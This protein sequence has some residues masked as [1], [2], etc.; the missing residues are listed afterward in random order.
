MLL[1]MSKKPYYCPSPDGGFPDFIMDLNNDTRRRTFMINRGYL[2]ETD[3]LKIIKTLI[4]LIKTLLGTDSNNIENFINYLENNI[5]LRDKILK[6]VFSDDFLLTLSEK[7]GLDI[8]IKDL[9]GEYSKRKLQLT[10]CVQVI[11][12]AIL[13]CPNYYTLLDELMSLTNLSKNRVREMIKTYIPYLE[14]I[15]KN[16]DADKWLP[17]SDGIYSKTAKNYVE[18]LRTC[19]RCKRELPIEKFS[20]RNRNGS[21]L[22]SWCKECKAESRLILRFTKKFKLIMERFNGRCTRCGVS[23]VFLLATVE[24]HHPNH[25]YYTSSWRLMKE[26]SYEKILDWAIRD[27]VVALCGNCHKEITSDI[28]TEFRDIILYPDLF[29]ISAREIH[30]FIQNTI[31][32]HPNYIQ[33]NENLKYS[34]KDS[35]MGYIRKRYTFLQ[36]Y[37]GVCIVCD[38]ISIQNLMA[39]SIHHRHPEILLK[40]SKWGDI[41]RKDSE[42]ILHILINEDC[43]ALCTNCHAIIN[44]KFHIY[45]KQIVS[46]RHLF[47][48]S[49]L[50]QLANKI[51]KKISQFNFDVTQINFYSPLKL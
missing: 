21:S 41:Y 20:K 6:I 24:F 49:E 33:A 37:N 36:L 3:F 13:K 28:Y 25:Y 16:I 40:K 12:L 51:N 47:L 2:Q 10:R 17:S 18:N 46:K 50:I 30:N 8:S 35:I 38:N 32:N 5:D 29:T 22:N 26:K 11:T 23:I 48:Y 44:S 15:Y 9:R 43:V 34:A 39:L 1:P 14:K 45:F 42:E 27:H 4:D 7:T 31:D 19:T